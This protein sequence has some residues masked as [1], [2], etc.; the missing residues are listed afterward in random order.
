MN[1]VG[2]RVRLLAAAALLAAAVAV[3][4][5]AAAI[6]D[7]NDVIHACYAR[8]GGTLRVIDAGV[9]NCK[10]GETSLNWNQVG[11]QGPKGDT[12]PA[13][14][15]GQQ[16]PKGDPGAT[17]PAGPQ[18]AQGPQGEPGPQGLQGP[19]GPAGPAGER[20]PQGFMGPAGPP[21]PA[22]TSRLAYA[23]EEFVIQEGGLFGNVDEETVACPDGLFAV[24]G[25]HR[26]PEKD[27]NGI[28]DS[29]LQLLGS[30]PSWNGSGWTVRLRNRDA[31]A[32][33]GY[34]VYAVCADASVLTTS[35]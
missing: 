21:G 28:F 22:G 12:G 34:A 5:A 32:D 27:L 13:G 35:S 20:G 19:A 9:T 14:P 23:R 16:G 1:R 8:S 3:G 6:P 2:A 7:E 33:F 10:Q 25:G 15:Q 30:H 26:L 11:P 31:I 17:G 29:E 4:G 24:A 18:G